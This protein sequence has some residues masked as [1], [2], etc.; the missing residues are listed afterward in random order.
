VLFR[1][2]TTSKS[3]PPL[4]LGQHDGLPSLDDTTRLSRQ[5]TGREATPQTIEAAR[6]ILAAARP[7][8]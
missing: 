2:L 1:P 4:A 5:L 7:R 6:K 3:R 8:P